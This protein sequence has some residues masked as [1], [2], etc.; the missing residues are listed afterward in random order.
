MS[1]RNCL[2]ISWS[3]PGFGKLKPLGEKD[4]VEL[5]AACRCGL[6]QFRWLALE[7]RELTGDNVDPKSR[8]LCAVMAVREELSEENRLEPR[9]ADEVPD[10]MLAWSND[11]L[12]PVDESAVEKEPFGAWFCALLPGLPH[13]CNLAPLSPTR[14]EAIVRVPGA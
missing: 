12:C 8:S 4:V 5:K 10:L 14:L 13:C 11:L 3:F 7:M 9:V 6:C 2:S 1:S